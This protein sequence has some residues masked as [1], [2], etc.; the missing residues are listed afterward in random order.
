MVKC[1]QRNVIISQYESSAENDYDW[2]SGGSFMERITE[3]TKKDIYDIFHNGIMDY[4]LF[5]IKI[6]YP[7]YGRLDEIE[8]LERFYNLREM[9]SNDS[10]Y[11]NA[12]DDIV[13]HTINNN[14]YPYCWV[15]KDDRFELNKGTDETYLKFICEVFYPYVRNEQKDW[16]KFLD[17]I[18]KLIR[19]DGY[20]LY[21]KE[22]ISGRDVYSWRLCGVGV[23]TEMSKDTL[24]DLIDDFTSGLLSKKNILAI[25]PLIRNHLFCFIL[26]PCFNLNG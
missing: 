10:R 3:I 15:F 9:E 4:N 2:V 5:D 24:L 13:Q 14:N 21:A 6:E 7:Y 17:E 23:A 12:H 8:F 20:E 19:I 26:I 25:F 11:I 18:N 22:Q 1:K 16:K